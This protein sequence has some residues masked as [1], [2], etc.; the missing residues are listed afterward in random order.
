MRFQIQNS[1]LENLNPQLPFLFASDTRQGKGLFREKD[2]ELVEV[3]VLEKVSGFW[4]SSMH[5]LFLAE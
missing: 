4:F 5:Q 1:T 2:R 3:P